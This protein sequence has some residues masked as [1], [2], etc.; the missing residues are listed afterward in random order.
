[1]IFRRKKR[2]KKPPPIVRLAH[3]FGWYPGPVAAYLLGWLEAIVEAVAIALL[4]INFVAVHMYVPSESMV[5]T[6]NPG[7]RFFVDRISYRFRSPDPGDVIVF[8]KLE[9]LR[10]TG[11]EQGS[12]AHEAGFLPGDRIVQPGN[13]LVGVAGEPVS[14]MDVIEARIVAHRGKELSFTVMRDARLV[15]LKV[16]VPEDAAG[17]RDLGIRYKTRYARY[18]K[19]LVAVG[20]QEVWIGDD[21]LVRVDGKPARYL[22][23]L[24]R[25]DDPAE[26]AASLDKGKIPDGILRTFSRNSR[27]LSPEAMVRVMDPGEEWKILDRWITPHGDVVEASFELFLEDDGIRI[28]PLY[29]KGDPRM[30]YGV[31]PTVVPEGLFFVLGDNTMNS[32]DSRYWGFVPKRAFIGE[33]F[34]RIWPLSRFGLMN[35]YFGASKW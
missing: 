9:E 30:R 5:P 27:P 25:T 29:F 35:G 31:K 15:E 6:I 1:M 11:V 12:P 21:G 26:A 10:V 34:L 23:F 18:V 17:L 24:Y 14:H 32:Y 13:P 20:G 4:I 8:W 2:K 28:Y 3:R 19:R 7:D 22:S 16:R 33:P